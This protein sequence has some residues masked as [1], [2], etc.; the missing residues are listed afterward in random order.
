[1]RVVNRR[2]AAPAIFEENGGIGKKRLLC[3]NDW[4]KRVKV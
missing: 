2:S 3:K 1:V 4:T